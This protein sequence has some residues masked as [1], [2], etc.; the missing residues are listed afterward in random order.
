[1]PKRKPVSNNAQLKMLE[2]RIQNKRRKNKQKKLSSKEACNRRKGRK[3][4]KPKEG[5]RPKKIEK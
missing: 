3:G 2:Q 4:S 5:L 1:M